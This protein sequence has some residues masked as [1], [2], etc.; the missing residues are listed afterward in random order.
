[1]SVNIDFLLLLLRLFKYWQLLPYQAG[2]GGVRFL[3]AHSHAEPLIL[4]DFVQQR[5]EEL[6]VVV[7]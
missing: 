3:R 7:I 6:V 1:L 5:L 2:I 4:L